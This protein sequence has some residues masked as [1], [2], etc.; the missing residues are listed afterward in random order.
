[1]TEI[2]L[3]PAGGTA[4]ADR[5]GEAPTAQRPWVCLVWDDPVNTMSYVTHVFASHFGYPVAQ[6]EQLMWRVH[7]RGKAIVASGDRETIEV[8]VTAMHAYGLWS[9][10]EP[11]S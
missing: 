9:T 7:T 8:H 3:S 11:G 5:P 2:P 10:M 4:L 1:M 6:A